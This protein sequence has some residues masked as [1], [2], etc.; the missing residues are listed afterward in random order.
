MFKPLLSA[1]YEER[2]LPNF[3]IMASPKL[4]GFRII[5]VN[6]VPMTRKLKRSVPN[7]VMCEALTGLPWLDGEII[8]GDPA[9]P[10]VFNHTSS[11][12]TA[13]SCP[14]WES[15]WA[16]YVFDSADPADA[17]LPFRERY[18]KTKR[19]VEQ[20]GHPHVKMVE[21]IM[22]DSLFGMYAYRD[23]CLAA[24]YEGIMLRD[25]EGRYKHGRST[26]KERILTKLK[27]FED[28]EAIITEV[29]AEQENMNEATVNAVGLQER[30]HKKANFVDKE[31]VGGYT[32]VTR[33]T[34]DRFGL[35]KTEQVEFYL[36]ASANMT[37]AALV[38][39]WPTRHQLIGKTVTFEYQLTPG[40]DK[41]RFPTFKC[42]RFD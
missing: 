17:A 23:E 19:F 37:D 39:M 21:H 9:A 25:P 36:G 29:H 7:L 27:V 40:S 15:D 13:K 38:D 32:C 14:E 30:A 8:C 18:I 12:V 42:F 6:G 11:G 22:V 4:D 5:I 1:D 33:R 41:P 28:A 34:G 16:Y 3:P 26:A 20:L 31:K 2:F 24:G 35:D 10:N